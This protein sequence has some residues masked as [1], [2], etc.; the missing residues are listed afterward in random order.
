MET[1][2]MALYKRIQREWTT[3]APDGDNHAPTDERPTYVVNVGGKVLRLRGWSLPDSKVATVGSECN[4]K[5]R[6]LAVAR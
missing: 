3:L 6:L 5:Y 2:T 4:G 1:S